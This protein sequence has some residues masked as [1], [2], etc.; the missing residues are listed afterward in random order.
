[1]AESVRNSIA[2][3]KSL[4]SGKGSTVARAPDQPSGGQVPPAENK[5]GSAA[6]AGAATSG[7]LSGKVTLSPALAGKVSPNDSL[8]VFARAKTG[9][10]A[11]LATLRLQVKD[12]PANFSL[13][14]SMAR[15]GVQLS[16]FPD[17]VIV[18]A[19]VSKSGSPMPQSGDLQGLSQP[20][21]IGAS[22]INVV[23]DQQ[24]P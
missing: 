1:L 7:T 14:D 13:N 8:Y 12:L 17:E 21:R 9:P 16:S 6:A 10:R 3:A 23:I 5:S 4:A 18:G 24:L 11:P 22:G 2:E 19:R 15:S 20:V